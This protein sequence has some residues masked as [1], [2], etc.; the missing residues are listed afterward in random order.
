MRKRVFIGFLSVA[1]MAVSMFPF[2]RSN[3]ALAPRPK[4]ATTGSQRVKSA[5]LPN[6]DVRLA[7]RGE[8]TDIDLSSPSNIRS[9][10]ENSD[11]AIRSRALAVEKFRSALSPDLAKNV[12]AM[13]NES[14]V[15]KNFFIDGSKLS[16]PRSDTPDNIARDFLRQH[17]S[18]FVL[19]ESAIAALKLNRED[20]DRGTTFIDY[21]QIVGG[22]RVFEGR[23]SGGRKWKRRGPFRPRRIS[24][25][26]SKGQA[27]AIL[28]RIRRDRK[29]F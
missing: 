11:R 25:D 2:I 23:S 27:Q 1:L 20:N 28:D 17:E 15:M 29:G 10:S 14:G 16:E 19:S 7:E 12:H 4:A 24:A 8:F 3:A 9:A 5:T 18:L 22:L 6:Y 26:R 21:S 13:V